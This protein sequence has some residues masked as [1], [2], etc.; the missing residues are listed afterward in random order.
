MYQQK[1]KGLNQELAPQ[2]DNF[3]N[4]PHFFS[5]KGRNSNRHIKF[6]KGINGSK[7]KLKW[8]ATRTTLLTTK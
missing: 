1:V 5:I 7:K 4:H 6:F 2:S 3:L 8:E